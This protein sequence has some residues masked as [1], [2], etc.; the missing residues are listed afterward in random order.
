[1][2]FRGAPE[3]I[4]LGDNILLMKFNQSNPK[5]KEHTSMAR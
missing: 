2:T 3:L 1:M 4:T 5:Q